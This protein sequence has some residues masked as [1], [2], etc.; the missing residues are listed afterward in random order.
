MSS[1]INKIKSKAEGGSGLTTGSKLPKM[2]PLKEDSIEKGTV[3][4]TDLPGK[5]KDFVS[6]I[7]EYFS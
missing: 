5:S 2:G 7:N 6:M 3:D 4:L 1:I